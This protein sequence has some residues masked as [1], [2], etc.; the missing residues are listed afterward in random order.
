MALHNSVEYN[1]I[2]YIIAYEQ[3]PQFNIYK[4]YIE[5][6]TCIRHYNY[7]SIM[8]IFKMLSHHYDK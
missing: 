2:I 4:G 7:E 5:S 8:T 3:P 1:N 6:S